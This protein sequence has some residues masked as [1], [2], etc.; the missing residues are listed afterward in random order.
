MIASKHSVTVK[1]RWALLLFLAAF[2]V[3]AHAQST[4]GSVLG[5]VQDATQAVVQ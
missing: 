5:T 3:S 2:A 1:F 4:F